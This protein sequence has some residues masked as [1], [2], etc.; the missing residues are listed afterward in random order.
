MD[1]ISSAASFIAIAVLAL[2]ST[3]VVYETITGIQN[4]PSLLHQ[5]AFELQNLQEVLQRII[6]L[7]KDPKQT[8]LTDF[9][10]LE[11][12]LRRCAGEM[13]AIEGRLGG[14]R[15]SGKLEKIWNKLKTYLHIKQIEEMRTIIC[16]HGQALAAGLSVTTM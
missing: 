5:L 7:S 13:K 10:V 11:R 2:Q 16:H 9:K 1:G 3:K 8:D 4:G 12:L 14:L 6:D 15:G